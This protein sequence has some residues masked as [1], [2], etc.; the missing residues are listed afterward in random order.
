M[1]LQTSIWL[2]A[3]IQ[4]VKILSINNIL[5][6]QPEDSFSRWLSQMFMSY[7]LHMSKKDKHLS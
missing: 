3:C 1:S 7:D 2:I 6:T 4:N 5:L